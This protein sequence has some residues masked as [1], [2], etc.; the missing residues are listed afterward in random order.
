MC[1][2]LGP[3]AG[4]SWLAYVGVPDDYP[5]L[6]ELAREIDDGMWEVAQEILAERKLEDPVLR[7]MADE[8]CSLWVL[9]SVPAGVLPAGTHVEHNGWYGQVRA[10]AWHDDRRSDPPDRVYVDWRG[11]LPGAPEQ[12]GGYWDP[13]PRINAGDQVDARV[14]MPFDAAPLLRWIEEET[15]VATVR[16]ARRKTKTIRTCLRCGR[17]G[18]HGF[19]A[20][21][22]GTGT[23]YCMGTVACSRRRA[24]RKTF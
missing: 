9:V 20:A 17:R 2:I 13:T 15:G 5:D 23:A 22:D 10:R 11:R 18:T 7:T 14:P 4:E 6:T 1:G 3:T 21:V 19:R 16:R 8:R 24:A 12:T